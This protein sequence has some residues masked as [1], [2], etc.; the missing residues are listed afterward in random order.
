MNA[1][2]RGERMIVAAGL[3]V[4][5][6][7]SWL[8][9]AALADA[10]QAMSDGAGSV[11]MGLMPMGRRWGPLEFWLCFAMWAVMMIAMMVPSAGPMLLAF[12]AMVR[13]RAGVASPGRRFVAFLLG[14]V[15]VWGGFSLLAAALQWRLRE[16]AVMTDMMVSTS[17]AWDAG[18]LLAAGAWQLAPAKAVCLSRCRTPLAFLLS[19]WREGTKG[20]WVMGLR[21]GGFCVGCCWAL[22]ALL[23]VGGVMNLLWIALLA[24]AV[25]RGEGAAIRHRDRQGRRPGPVRRRGMAAAGR[26]KAQGDGRAR[27][28]GTRSLA[29]LIFPE[30]RK[31]GDDG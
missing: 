18:L 5:T 21:H 20:A 10:M 9:L 28:L 27:E 30:R 12:H 26:M 3:A 16:A 6:L 29:R 25:L 13:R 19:E 4:L 15:V 17:R 11:F 23:F 14:Y 1:L 22:M 31:E 8:Y 2:L 24:G 7:L